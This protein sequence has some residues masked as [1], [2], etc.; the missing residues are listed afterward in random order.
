MIRHT[1]KQITSGMKKKVLGTKEVQPK[2]KSAILMNSKKGFKQTKKK[3][4]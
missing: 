3:S 1:P 2:K 4:N